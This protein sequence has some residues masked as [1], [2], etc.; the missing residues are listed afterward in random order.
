MIVFRYTVANQ[1]FRNLKK[2]SFSLDIFKW[3]ETNAKP[4]CP[5]ILPG[6][7]G[8]EESWNDAFYFLMASN[9]RELVSQQR[10][11]D[12]QSL[13]EIYS[14]KIPISKMSIKVQNLLKTQMTPSFPQRKLS[15]E[16]QNRNHGNLGISRISPKIINFFKVLLYHSVLKVAKNV[17]FEVLAI[18]S[19]F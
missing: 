6:K 7:S 3:F 2:R 16:G 5:Q 11:K 17:S 18:K 12:Y 10:T 19:E 14:N 1:D 15:A 13:F 8:H 4:K 9:S